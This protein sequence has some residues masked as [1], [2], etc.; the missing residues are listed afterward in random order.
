[1]KI[2]MIIDEQGSRLEIEADHIRENVKEPKELI[3]IMWDLFERFK[4]LGFIREGWE[5]EE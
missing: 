4:E 2:R 5:G 1:M 3:S